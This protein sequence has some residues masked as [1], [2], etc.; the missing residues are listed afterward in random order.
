[1]QRSMAILVALWVTVAAAAPVQ[2]QQ[3]AGQVWTLGEWRAELKADGWLELWDLR[4]PAAPKLSE[5]LHLHGEVRDV[6]LENGLLRVTVLEPQQ[7]QWR[8]TPAGQW[9]ALAADPT[10]SGDA[11]VVQV[12]SGRAKPPR[13]IGVV[14]G[15]F[16]GEVEIAV[17]A[18]VKPW[19]D[20]PV[21]LVA[22]AAAS[23]G[24]EEDGPAPPRL[25]LPIRRIEE[26]RVFAE[27]PRGATAETGEWVVATRQR[28]D[29]LRWLPARL[30]YDQWWR[31]GMAP[32]LP[33]SDTVGT[34]LHFEAGARLTDTWEL[35]F[36][37]SPLYLT[38]EGQLG[39]SLATATLR[40]N[41]D[42]WA[43]GVAAGGGYLT[44]FECVWDG[45]STEWGSWRAREVICTTWQPVVG[46]EARVG[47]QDGLHFGLGLVASVGT[48]GWDPLL[49]EG[50]IGVPLSKSTDIG[51]HWI[52]SRDPTMFEVTGRYALSGNGGAGS[53]YLHVGLGGVEVDIP[54]ADQ[55]EG[56]QLSFSLEFRP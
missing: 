2:A 48:L 36:R 43:V 1:M 20:Q 52:V 44:D 34:A 18:G 33:M 6:R 50:R 10:A 19:L 45:S 22:A 7:R 49:I 29:L 8:L 37:A 3:P 23:E 5:R 56:P 35:E 40:Y 55:L 47:A 26:G 17:E 31:I 15:V 32:V 39:T 28:P 42:Y 13:K 25:V 53:S 11:Q 16:A 24:D 27:L 9:V 30:A 41:D 54:G 4:D 46:G 38:T 12:R 14:K 51:I 21:G